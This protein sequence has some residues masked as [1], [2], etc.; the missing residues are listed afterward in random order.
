VPRS[1]EYNWG[2]ELILL[3]VRALD[4]F[5]FKASCQIGAFLGSLGRTEEGVSNGTSSRANGQVDGTQTPCQGSKGAKMGTMQSGKHMA[6][7]GES[8]RWG[9][10]A[11]DGM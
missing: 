9:R 11:S 4:E 1:I 8:E 5:V 2:T 6:I 3:S 7:K 10:K